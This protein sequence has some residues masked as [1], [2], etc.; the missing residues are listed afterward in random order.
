MAPA[1][2]TARAW[3]YVRGNESIRIVVEDGSI[4]IAGPGAQRRRHECADDCDALLEHSAL[5][6]QLVRDGWSLERMITE[7]RS[8][9]ERR[10]NTRGQDRR[11]GLRLVTNS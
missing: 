3:L 9:R 4:D 6:Q 5:E 1:E 11:R 7:R 10:S 8:G 2:T